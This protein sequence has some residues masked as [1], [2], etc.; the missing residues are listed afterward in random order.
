MIM[1]KLFIDVDDSLVIYH[2]ALADKPH[3]Y[4]VYEGLPWEPNTRLIEGIRAW[5]VTNPHGLIIVWS[6][7]GYQYADYWA[8]KLLPDLKVVCL[9]KTKVA[10]T[11]VSAKDIVV[12]DQELK[13][14]CRVYRPDEWPE[15]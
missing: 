13:M 10:M 15:E 11:L 14:P 7:G 3:P 1:T 12:D 4:G 5:S 2:D 9:S 6:G 8:K